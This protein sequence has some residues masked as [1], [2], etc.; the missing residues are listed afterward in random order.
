[1]AK[2]LNAFKL[3]ISLKKFCC[4][5]WKWGQRR[6]VSNRFNWEDIWWKY[7]IEEVIVLLIHKTYNLSTFSRL[8]ARLRSQLT[9]THSWFYFYTWL[10]TVSWYSKPSAFCIKYNLVWWTSWWRHFASISCLFCLQTYLPVS[11]FSDM[12]TTIYCVHCHKW[13]I[14]LLE[15]SR[16]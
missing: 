15:L 9:I 7:Y 12:F 10:T 3:Q 5:C 1:M 14:Y 2:I 8:W 16:Y 11:K 6:A 13:R 4:I